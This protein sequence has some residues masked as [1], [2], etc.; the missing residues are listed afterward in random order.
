[1]RSLHG[2]LTVTMKFMWLPDN[3]RAARAGRIL[4]VVLLVLLLSGCRWLLSNTGPVPIVVASDSI[5]LSWDSDNSQ[6]AGQPSAVDYYN[7]YYRPYGT[8]EWRL[9]HA[10]ASNRSSTTIWSGELDFGSYEFGVQE[11][12]RDS[13]T[14]AIHGSSDFS[15]WPPGGW[16]VVWQAP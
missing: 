12:Y 4:A 1:M 7:V 11:V 6:L 9:L 10:T 15:S 5:V 16:Y 13:R 8:L 3:N 14:S 2:I